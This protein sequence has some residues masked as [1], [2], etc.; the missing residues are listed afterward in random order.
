[1][2]ILMCFHLLAPQPWAV[3]MS[4]GF[5]EG[6]CSL[7]GRE[8]GL[9]LWDM[10]S[11]PWFA[12]N[13]LGIPGLAMKLS[14]CYPYN[15]SWREELSPLPALWSVCYVGWLV[16]HWTED[17]NIF[18]S[19]NWG[20]LICYPRTGK[21]GFLSPCGDIMQS[22]GVWKLPCSAFLLALL[23]MRWFL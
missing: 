21:P 15:R 18:C 14:C 10:D 13:L 19:E 23:M 1:M 5:E 16:S 2:I 12:S 22:T 6:Q 11:S 20:T 3:R 7:K 17:R 9:E 4:R 8:L